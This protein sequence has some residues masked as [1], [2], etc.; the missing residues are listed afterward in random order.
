MSAFDSADLAVIKNA[1]NAD[2]T[3]LGEWN[4]G[5]R[6]AL[7]AY[8]NSVPSPSQNVTREDVSSDELSHCLVASDVAAIAQ[9]AQTVPT[10]AAQNRRIDFTKANVA[11]GL[12]SIFPSTSQTY[13]NIMQVAVRP[14]TRL[15]ALFLTNGV[16]AHYGDTID[17]PT[18]IAAMGA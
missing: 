15:E 18:L 5:N 16:S 9:W 11:G 3:A 17:V 13:A 4:A 1:I 7:C 2:A 10:L 14:A 8:L 6:G 12:T